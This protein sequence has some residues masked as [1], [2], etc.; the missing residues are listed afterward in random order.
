MFNKVTL[1]GRS[2]PGRTETN[3]EKILE[4][5]PKMTPIHSSKN[6]LMMV[7]EYLPLKL[8]F[9]GNWKKNVF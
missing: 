1:P 6:T 2:Y 7:G 3:L 4:F 8:I 5:D 9:D